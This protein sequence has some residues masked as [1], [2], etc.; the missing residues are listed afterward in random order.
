MSIKKIS[1]A[2]DHGGF[3]LKE[4]VIT[5]LNECGFKTYD[6]GTNSAESVD[7]PDFAKKLT[8]NVSSGTS[9]FGI[10]ICGTG[11][12]M[13]ISANKAR[14]IRAAN[15]TNSTMAKLTRAHNNANVLC[16][17]ARIVGLELAKDIISAFLS[18]DFEGG[19]HER[20]ISKIK[21]MEESHG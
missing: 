10:L 20:R 12:G 9:D 19:R 8:E 11:I 1:I 17:G 6:L 7:Y 21:D 5:F 15:C 3:E 2:C 16:L 4:K 14:G 13:E 18:T